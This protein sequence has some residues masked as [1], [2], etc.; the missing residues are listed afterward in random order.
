MQGERENNMKKVIERT[1]GIE[2][3]AEAIEGGYQVYTMD[4]EKYKKLKESTF[5][6]YFKEVE[7][8][9]PNSE[10]ISDEKREQMIEKIKKILAL[11]ENN[12]SEEEALSAALKAH[13]LMIKYNI[14]ESEV[15]AEEIK[16]DIV[17]TVSEQKHNSGLHKWRLQL[18][19]IIAKSFRCKAY[20]HGQDVTFR[21]Y[22]DDTKVALEVYL[23]LYLIGDKLGSKAYK[24]KLSKTGS[25]KGAYNS[26]VSGFVRG[27]GDAF[28][29][30]CTALVVVTPTEVEE[31]W[32]SFS[33]SM[34][35]T[36]IRLNAD[37]AELYKKGYAEG[38]DVVRARGLE[39]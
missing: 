28:S 38:K 27:V 18:A 24:D 39:G 23:M 26:F 4:G 6:K 31:E 16:E 9:Q 35:S 8:S 36:S 14:H 17:S 11:A 22:R 20:L 33:K 7:D 15:S 13:K 29:A 12:P 37:D 21:G 32:K 34:K 30:Q 3:R 25:G 19:G 5:K 1:T 10:Q 2:M